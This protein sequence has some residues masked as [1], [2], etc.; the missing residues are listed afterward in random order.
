MSI[1][2]AAR[3]SSRAIFVFSSS[4]T[5]GDGV[6]AVNVTSSIVTWPSPSLLSVDVGDVS[7]SV[8]AGAVTGDDETESSHFEWSTVKV[9]KRVTKA[10]AFKHLIVNQS[11]I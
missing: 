6:T 8:S 4:T 10:T 9:R 2:E 5:G 11:H 3:N 1:A 7:E